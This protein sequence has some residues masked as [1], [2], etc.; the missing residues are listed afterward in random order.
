M[1]LLSAQANE[2][3]LA[4]I[5]DQD[6]DQAAI[7]QMSDTEDG[8]VVVDRLDTW[9]ETKGK[10]KASPAKGGGKHGDPPRWSKGKGK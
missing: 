5:P 6:D 3:G 4:P 8:S 9:A 1:L 2:N 10:G 7:A